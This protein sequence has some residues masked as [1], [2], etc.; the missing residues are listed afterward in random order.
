MPEKLKGDYC[1]TIDF[2]K[3]SPNPERIFQAM[4]SLLQAFQKLDNALIDSIDST[5]EPI[6]LLED[7]EAGSLKTWLTTVLKNTPDEALTNLDW[8]PLIGKFLTKAK[9]IVLRSLE[10]RVQITDA[11]IIEDIQAEIYDT[12]AKTDVKSFPNY[13]PVQ[14]RKLINS[15]DDINKSLQYL[16]KDDTAFYQT[17]EDKAT[18]N[19][20]LEVSP[21]EIEDL[22]VS[23]V[24]NNTVIMILKVNKPDY[25]GDSMWTFKHEQRT[26]NAK[27]TDAQWVQKFQKR[28]VDVRPGDSLKCEVHVSVK[29]G[30]DM[31]VVK[32]VY[33]VKKVLTTINFDQKGQ[34]LLIE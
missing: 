12:A 9:Y 1:I 20:M 29:Y 13:H 33:T 21:E 27:I 14:T 25:L 5:I 7:I 30:K 11:T 2:K 32:T 26:I 10:G 6:I 19:L 34:Q 17:Q 31:A 3:D 24:I 8:K 18:F 28:E 15:I 4:T 23:E 16:N 22:M